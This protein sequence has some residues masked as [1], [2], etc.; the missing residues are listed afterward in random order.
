[1]NHGL[2]GWNRIALATLSGSALMVS[3]GVHAQAPSAQTSER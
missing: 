3:T 2:P 1:M